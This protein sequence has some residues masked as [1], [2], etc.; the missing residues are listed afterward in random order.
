ME[1][2]C[3]LGV[4]VAF[5]GTQGHHQCT[6]S[7]CADSG[8]VSLDTDA[9][10]LQEL[11]KAGRLQL[12]HGRRHRFA[13]P[14][15]NARNSITILQIHVL[16]VRVDIRKYDVISINS[17]IFA[18]KA[19][20]A[21]NGPQFLH[22]GTVPMHTGN[23]FTG[24]PCCRSTMRGGGTGRWASGRTSSDRL[25]RNQAILFGRC[26]G[27][28]EPFRLEDLSG[29]FRMLGIETALAFSRTFQGTPMRHRDTTSSTL[30]GEGQRR[31]KVE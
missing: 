14:D 11:R 28:P 21:T 10:H 26:H 1:V 18:L 19:S 12:R 9:A 29:Y 8:Y 31:D 5:E 17:G 15:G 27:Q 6:S 22:P 4:L 24:G 23:G 7:G 13:S 25:V 16:N 30:A 2:R 3:T 20:A